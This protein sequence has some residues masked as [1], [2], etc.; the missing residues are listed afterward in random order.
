M[1]FLTVDGVPS[2]G[3]TIEFGTDTYEFDTDSSVT[4]GNI[5][6]D[7]SSA[8]N[9]DDVVLVIQTAFN[10][11][12]SYSATAVK[13]DGTAT[14]TVLTFGTGAPSTGDTVTFG[15]EVYEFTTDGTTPLSAPTNIR[16]D[17]TG[18]GGA[19]TAVTTAETG[20]QAFK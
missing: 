20:A 12:T 14:E 9:E 4:S 11:N 6:I 15:T 18:D 17:M 8:T 5:A 7:I 1:N 13:T 3:D 2:D 10:T 19:F 16:I